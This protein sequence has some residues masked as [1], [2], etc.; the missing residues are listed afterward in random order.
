MNTLEIWNALSENR[1]TQKYFKGVF[2][3]D[4][5]PKLIKKKPALFVVNTDRSNKPGSHWV[6]IYLP[7]KG[8]PEYFDSYGIQ[9]IHNEF[10]E[11]FKRNKFTK[12]LYNKTQL[13]NLLSTVCGQY[14]CVYLLYKAQKKSLENFI[15]TNFEKDKFRKNDKRVETLFLKNFERRRYR[16]SQGNT[17]IKVLIKNKRLFGGGSIGAAGYAKK[18]KSYHVQSCRSFNNCYK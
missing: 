14:C 13:Q 8:K 4:L 6:A 17:G 15:E 3:L 5:L 9:P 10:L 12:V 2:P 11:F 7:M 16:R 18:N 1:Y